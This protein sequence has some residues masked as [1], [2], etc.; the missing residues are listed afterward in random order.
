MYATIV[1]MINVLTDKGWLGSENCIILKYKDL[2]GVFF[3]VL[4]IYASVPLHSDF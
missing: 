2:V 3:Y 1:F 4:V